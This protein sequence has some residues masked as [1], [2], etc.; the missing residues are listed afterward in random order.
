MP[1][2]IAAPLR[3]ANPPRT[4]RLRLSTVEPRPVEWTAARF[5]ATGPNSWRTLCPVV[6]DVGGHPSP[7]GWVVT[8]PEGYE[9]DGV[10]L[11]GPLRLLT[12]WTWR[13]RPA[14]LIHDYLLDCR[15]MDTTIADGIFLEAARATPGCPAWLASVA[16][17]AVSLW[18]AVRRRFRRAS[19][20]ARSALSDHSEGTP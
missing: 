1:A 8:V 9:T 13:L 11:P 4:D 5:E 3:P 18:G 19:A 17:V 6:Y 12:R 20:A 16:F 15:D 10:T 2:P 14:A 7:R